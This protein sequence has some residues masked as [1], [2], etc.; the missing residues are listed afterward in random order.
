[1]AEPPQLLK[2]AVPSPGRLEAGGGGTYESP[3][4]ANTGQHRPT[5]PSLEVESAHTSPSGF[6]PDFPAL[7]SQPTDHCGESAGQKHARRF[8]A[9]PKGPGH[10]GADGDT[11]GE[12]FG[13]PPSCQTCAAPPARVRAGD[14]TPYAYPQRLVVGRHLAC[15]AGLGTVP[16]PLHPR[17]K[18]EQPGVTCSCPA[19]QLPSC[20][21]APATAAA[22]CT[23]REGD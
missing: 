23:S 2:L 19:A 6:L 12:P 13:P 3:G 11:V 4:A 18:S 21:P 20:C 15:N 14:A 9:R 8:S 16:T 1:M 5:R 10:Q 17:G 22:A 7:P